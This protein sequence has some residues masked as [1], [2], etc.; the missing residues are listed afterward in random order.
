MASGDGKPS[1]LSDL[2][3]EDDEVDYANETDEHRGT[4]V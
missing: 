1:A 2:N 4:L 3:A